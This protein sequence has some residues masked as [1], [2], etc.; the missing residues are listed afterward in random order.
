VSSDFR[1]FI[2]AAIEHEASDVL[3]SVGSVPALRVD[4]DLRSLKTPALTSE[5][6][7]A[8]LEVLLSTAQREQLRERRQLDFVVTAA[9]RRF[10]GS[11]VHASGQPSIAMRLLPARVPTPTELGLP[12]VLVESLRQPWGLMLATG[13]AGSGK[14]TTLASLVEVI[15]SHRPSHIVTIEDPIEF[16]HT[17]KHA[18]IDHQEVGIDTPSFGAALRQVLRH[19]PD[20]IVV[21]EIRDRETAEAVLTIAETGHLVLST[22]HANDAVQALDRIISLFPRDHRDYA[23]QQLAMIVNAIVNQRLV[24]GKAGGRVLAAE[25]LRTSSSVAHLIRDRRTSQLHSVLERERGNGSQSMNHA[26]D[27]LVAR[28]KI[29]AEEARR[30]VNRLESPGAVVGPR[31]TE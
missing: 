12:P 6:V 14:T 28:D 8:G 23:S 21:G 17:P 4:G 26:L 13:P 25:V 1:R 2:Q 27:Q 24:R 19:N 5:D 3:L 10:R 18:I 30:H 7:H 31:D 20:V 11:A 29:T 22:V 16:V 9:G 15:N